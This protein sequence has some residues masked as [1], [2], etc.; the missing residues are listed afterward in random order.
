MYHNEGSR[1]HVKLIRYNILPTGEGV[2]SITKP[3]ILDSELHIPKAYVTEN[4][5]QLRTADIPQSEHETFP[6]K[7]RY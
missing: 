1:K 3:F 6:A 4:R 7:S 5:L 2:G